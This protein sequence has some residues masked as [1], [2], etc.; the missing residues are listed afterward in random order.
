MFH[1]N[2]DNVSTRMMSFLPRCN[3]CSEILPS[4][5]L[6]AYPELQMSLIY[7]QIKFIIKLK[8]NTLWKLSF[9]RCFLALY[10]E[11][12]YELGYIIFDRS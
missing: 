11:M 3:S 9:E 6:D 2:Q 10:N 8:L 4:L 5:S 12:S 7:Y 1:D